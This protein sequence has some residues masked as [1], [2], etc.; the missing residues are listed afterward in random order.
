MQAHV[1][2]LETRCQ[3]LTQQL[4]QAR[5]SEEKQGAALRRLEETVSHGDALRACQQAEEVDIL[6]FFF[7]A[8]YFFYWHS[9]ILTL[10]HSLKHPFTCLF[11]F[12]RKEKQ[13]QTRNNKSTGCGEK[14][15]QAAEFWH[16]I[17]I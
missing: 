2:E 14:K 3:S 11:S 7:F 17:G 5:S 13:Q 4:E 9:D 6:F 15:F 10:V 16:N 1:E 8:I 12:L